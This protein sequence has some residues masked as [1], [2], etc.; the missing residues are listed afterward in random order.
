VPVVSTVA[1][2]SSARFCTSCGARLST[3]DTLTSSPSDSSDDATGEVTIVHDTFTDQLPRH[4]PDDRIGAPPPEVWAAWQPAASMVHPNGVTTGPS[5]TRSTINRW[6]GIT[7][8]GLVA[9]TIATESDPTPST[10]TDRTA[11]ADDALS[12][13]GLGPSTAPHRASR[14]RPQRAIP[15]A[16]AGILTAIAVTIGAAVD[17]LSVS[18]TATGDL[19]RTAISNGYRSGT[20]H[21]DDLSSGA[22]WAAVICA[23]GL[24]AGAV[25]SA[26]G[27]RWAPGLVAGSGLSATGLCAVLI[28]LAQSPIRAAESVASRADGDAIV[29]VTITREFG[30]WT[31]LIAAGAGLVAFFG[32]LD[33]VAADY[34]ND[35]NP[36][37]AA[38]GAFCALAAAAGPTLATSDASWLDNL[39]VDAATTGWDLITIIARSTQLIGIATAGVVG[40]LIVRR[41][42]LAMVAGMVVPSM[43]LLITA[44]VDMGTDPVGPGLHNPG[45]T[46]ADVHPVT[47]VALVACAATLA[48]AVAIAY[49][50]TERGR[51]N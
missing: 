15:S 44:W 40:F 7:L 32:S 50:R 27:V 4:L 39:T 29:E 31:L 37:V 45:T 42:G 38:I 1:E 34:R 21:A 17:L 9:D 43:V 47:L 3:T 10:V 41:S 49:D 18:S 48:V 5:T 19:L 16:V 23:A 2:E 11:D 51:I 14:P 33:D 46:P 13:V 25:G 6:R 26:L 35:A 22:T 20:W 12:S 36:I 24:A 8:A 30:W 28:A